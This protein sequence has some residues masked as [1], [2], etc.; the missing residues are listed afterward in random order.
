MKNQFINKL[1]FVENIVGVYRNYT[2]IGSLGKFLA[3]VRITFEIGITVFFFFMNCNMAFSP[4]FNTQ[5][6]SWLIIIYHVQNLLS[7]TVIIICGIYSS[8]YYKLFLEDFL[9]IYNCLHKNSTLTKRLKRL[10]I[11]FTVTTISFSISSLTFTTYRELSKKV[12]SSDVTTWLMSMSE[13]TIEVRFIMEHIV[14]GTFVYMVHSF[15]LC[16]NNEISAIQT[17]Y[18]I[19]EKRLYSDRRQDDVI[20][21]VEQIEKLTVFYRRITTCCKNLS[22]T[23][24]KQVCNKLLYNE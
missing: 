23:F 3:I 17:K 2:V 9:V 15:L 14:F 24:H 21:T 22:A 4:P 10:K 8:G 19:R 20:L 13:V 11:F 16:L 18:N 7:T 12:Y 6:K 5:G 1:V